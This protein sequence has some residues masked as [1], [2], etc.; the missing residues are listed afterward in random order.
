MTLLHKFEA[1]DHHVL[2]V[3][4]NPLFNHSAY[5]S[6]MEIAVEGE[7]YWAEI[8]GSKQG[9][10]SCEYLVCFKEEKSS[11]SI[12]S[13]QTVYKLEVYTINKRSPCSLGTPPAIFLLDQFVNKVHI[14]GN[15]A[16]AIDYEQSKLLFLDLVNL[17][18]KPHKISVC[19]P[20]TEADIATLRTNNQ[21]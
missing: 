12:F 19:D 14:V 9:S 17:E 18:K 8:V 1:N 6:T 4:I 2:Q 20:D 7:L 16:I 21:N 3:A 15:T 13:M 5:S 11:R 10:S